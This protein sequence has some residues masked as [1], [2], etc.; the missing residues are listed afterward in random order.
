MSGGLFEERLGWLFFPPLG[1][2]AR[3]VLAAGLV[4]SGLMGDRIQ[5]S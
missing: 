3:Q 4:F 5:L 2:T 1:V